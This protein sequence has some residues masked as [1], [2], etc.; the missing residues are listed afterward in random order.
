MFGVIDE[1]HKPWQMQ[2]PPQRVQDVREDFA[3]LKRD[4]Y[5]PGNVDHRPK[6][7][8]LYSAMRETW[9][10]TVED[11]IFN[12]VIQ[13][14]KPEIQT[15][16]LQQVA[17]DPNADYPTIF[18]GMKR[19]SHYSGHDRAEDLPTELPDEAQIEADIDAL[20]DFVRAARERQNAFAN[21]PRYEHG[22][23]PEFLV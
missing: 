17:F 23:E 11:I 3:A 13:R 15:Q 6:V 18:E 1:A 22:P 19:C 14:F 8:L 5:D 20:N 7:V 21:A 12:G 4:G 2:K 9:E 10:K 16:R